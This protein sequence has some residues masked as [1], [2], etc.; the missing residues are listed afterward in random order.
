MRLRDP[1][2]FLVCYVRRDAPANVRRAF[3][4]YAAPGSAVNRE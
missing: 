4:P 2:F 1:S 3:V